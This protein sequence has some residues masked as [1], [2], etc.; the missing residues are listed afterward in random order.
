MNARITLGHVALSAADPSA[1]AACYRT[2]FGFDLVCEGTHPLAGEIVLLSGRPEEDHELALHARPEARH[3]GLRGD[4][5]RTLR[6]PYREVRH[7]GLV[8]LLAQGSGVA[9]S[10][11]FRDPEGNGVEVYWPTDGSSYG[12]GGGRP[13]DLSGG[14]PP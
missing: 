2:L 14:T 10:F 11:F 13:L 5:E 9:H 12:V 1:Q 3:V 8:V 4:S 6:E 7:R